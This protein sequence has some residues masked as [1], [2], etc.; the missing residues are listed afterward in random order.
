MFVQNILCCGILFSP[1]SYPGSTDFPY[2]NHYGTIS[3]SLSG[4]TD[5]NIVV[6]SHSL[7]CCFFRID[8]FLLLGFFNI[9]LCGPTLLG[10]VVGCRTNSVKT[11][12]SNRLVV[13][14][15]WLR[16]NWSGKLIPEWSSYSEFVYKWLLSISSWLKYNRD[17][18]NLLD[19]WI[20]AFWRQIIVQSIWF[21]QQGEGVL[22]L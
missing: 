9:N 21:R 11:T 6:Y 2:V 13:E 15:T 10:F 14:S 5:P 17:N 7:V 4:S 1:P 3:S 8:F 12:S 16:S 19:L 22:F 20:I 18:L